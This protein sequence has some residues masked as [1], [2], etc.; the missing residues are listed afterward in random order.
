M[1]KKVC[2]FVVLLLICGSIVTFAEERIIVDDAENPEL[3]KWWHVA[4]SAIGIEY[5]D[6]FAYE[7]KHSIK[8]SYNL[9]GT[10]TLWATAHNNRFEFSGEDLETP[11]WILRFKFFNPN[12]EIAGKIY[13]R[14]TFMDDKA[15]WW[16]PAG[17]GVGLD[18]WDYDSDIPV[19]QFVGY[20]GSIDGSEQ[21]DGWYTYEV[22]LPVGAGLK[23][24]KSIKVIQIKVNLA[25]ENLSFGPNGPGPNYIYVDNIEVVPA[26]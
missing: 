24:V 14:L 12:K 10:G 5:T 16:W 3:A 19:G 2:L 21:G 17:Y 8:I 20:S 26:N 15:N 11:G 4:E 13:L 6:E 9:G 1:L 22:K 23:K 25:D 18:E 7:G